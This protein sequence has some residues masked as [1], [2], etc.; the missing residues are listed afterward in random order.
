M[1]LPRF[2]LALRAALIALI[3]PALAVAAGTPAGTSISN[4]ASTS[5]TAPDSA[6]TLQV[7]SNQVVTV[8]QAGAAPTEM[9]THAA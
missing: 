7:A 4:Q 1:R 5:F 8:V 3:L 2:P 6:Q 9:E